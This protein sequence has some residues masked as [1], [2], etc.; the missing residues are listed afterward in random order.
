VPCPTVVCLLSF[1]VLA[2][3]KVPR[4]DLGHV[5]IGADIGN[6]AQI[7]DSLNYRISPIDR[8]NCK[9]RREMGSWRDELRLNQLLS[10]TGSTDPM[11]YLDNSF[12][13]SLL[14][15]AELPVNSM[16]SR[17]T[18]MPLYIMFQYNHLNHFLQTIPYTLS[19]SWPC[20]Y[21]P[22]AFLS[23]DIS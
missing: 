17:M 7:R 14:H 19:R 9:N 8:K 6:T 4:S 2:A 23:P 20:F 22:D 21:N 11:S 1:D 15:D 16:S 18:L 13:M 10:S 12:L 5:F 3:L